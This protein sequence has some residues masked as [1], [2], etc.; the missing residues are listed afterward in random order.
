MSSKYQ[1]M[2]ELHDAAENGNLEDVR[3]LLDGRTPQSPHVF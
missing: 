3:G 1:T 2:P